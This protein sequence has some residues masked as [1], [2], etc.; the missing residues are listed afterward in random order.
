MLFTNDVL[1]GIVEGRIDR[2]FRRWDRPSVRE[3]TE[4]RASVGIVRIERIESVALADISDD[5]ARRAGFDDAA[6]AVD[7]L[8]GQDGGEVFRIALSYGGAD[9]RVALREQTDL[10]D[11][12]VQEIAARLARFDRASRRGP[13]TADTVKIIA[14]Q[15]ATPAVELAAAIGHDKEAIKRNVRKLK[16]LGLTISLEPGY[17][18]S[19]RGEEVH[20]RLNL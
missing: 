18:L 19:P 20:R 10:D 11:E 7:H 13:W 12:E 1:R 2:A 3:G 5:D 9:P 17:R 16:E 6:V 14:E 15:P 8:V 4:L